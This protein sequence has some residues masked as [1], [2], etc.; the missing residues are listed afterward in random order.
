MYFLKLRYKNPTEFNE[1]FKSQ[2]VTWRNSNIGTFD[3]SSLHVNKYNSAIFPSLCSPMW[4]VD[5]ADTIA[6][7]KVRICKVWGAKKQVM[8]NWRTRKLKSNQ[9][10]PGGRGGGVGTY[11]SGWGVSGR[12]RGPAVRCPACSCDS[13]DSLGGRHTPSP[14]PP[15]SGSWCLPSSSGRCP[16]IRRHCED[17]G[18]GAGTEATCCGSPTLCLLD[19]QMKVMVTAGLCPWQRFGVEPLLKVYCN[20]NLEKTSSERVYHYVIKKMLWVWINVE[21]RHI[22]H[23]YWLDQGSPTFLILTTQKYLLLLSITQNNLLLVIMMYYY[24]LLSENLVKWLAVKSENMS[25]GGSSGTCHWTAAPAGC[26][27]LPCWS[28][29]RW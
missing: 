21:K 15:R 28:R 6:M 19:G 17:A 14:S 26:W 4:K 7:C 10:R 11:S 5:M 29:P 16:V 18:Q 13:P 24:Y 2:N 3:K 22:S 9:A 25:C 8:R 20:F 12:W 27:G 23:N 1:L